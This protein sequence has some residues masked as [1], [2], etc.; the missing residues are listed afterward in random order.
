MYHTFVNS[1]TLLLIRVQYNQSIIKHR[2]NVLNLDNLSMIMCTAFIGSLCMYLV[3]RQA[4]ISWIKSNTIRYWICFF[5]LC[6]IATQILITVCYTSIIGEWLDRI[7]LGIVL[8]FAWKQYRKLDMVIQRHFGGC[9][10]VNLVSER[11]FLTNSTHLSFT[12][13]N[14]M[15]LISS[16]C[17]R[18]PCEYTVIKLIKLILLFLS[19]FVVAGIYFQEQDLYFRLWVCIRIWYYICTLLICM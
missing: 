6:W 12:P 14:A 7:L 3:A 11:D 18:R 9:S 16:M 4:R 10:E 1:M 19:P 13:Q 17:F 2:F 8:V 5:L 15:F